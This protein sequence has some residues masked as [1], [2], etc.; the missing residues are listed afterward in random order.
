MRIHD[1]DVG[2][3]RRHRLVAII[4]IIV[5][6]IIAIISTHIAII[7]IDFIIVSFRIVQTL[8]LAL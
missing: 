2:P 4:T 6:I 1:S 3:R 5:V 7:A 8:L